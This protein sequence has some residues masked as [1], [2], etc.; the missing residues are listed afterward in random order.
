[1]S[2]LTT[3]GEVVAR[4]GRNPVLRV[5]GW[6]IS[7]LLI[8][9]TVVAGNA[10]IEHTPGSQEFSRPYIHSGPIGTELDGYTFVA[11]VDGVKGA[12]SAELDGDELTTDGVFVVVSVTLTARQEPTHLQTVA[13]VDQQGRVYT[14]TRSIDQGLFQYTLEPDVPITGDLL[15][16]VPRDAAPGLKVR[17]SSELW[18]RQNLNQTVVQVDLGISQATVTT[19]LSAR[20][21]VVAE[22]KVKA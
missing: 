14:W 17:L 13:V 6:P 4:P 2:D 12:P 22:P 10:I 7:L 8:V 9:A 18:A 15:F 20:S 21:L 5:L 11:T 19:W 3:D 1:M 16:E